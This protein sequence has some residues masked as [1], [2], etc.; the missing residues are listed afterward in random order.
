MIRERPAKR[1]P[2]VPA[3]QMKLGLKFMSTQNGAACLHF[4]LLSSRHDLGSP[5]SPLLSS[6]S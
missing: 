1:H 3:E 5:P 4:C 2:Q 6:S